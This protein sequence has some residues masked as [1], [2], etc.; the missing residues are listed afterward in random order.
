M[1]NIRGQL[2]YMVQ[3]S[4]F[5]AAAYSP[6][7]CPYGA[8]R[9]LNSSSNGPVASPNRK[10]PIVTRACQSV[11][12]R[13][14]KLSILLHKGLRQL[15]DSC[16]CCSRVGQMYM[17][18]RQRSIPHYKGCFLIGEHLSLIQFNQHT[19]VSSN[20]LAI[21]CKSHQFSVMS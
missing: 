17:H 5:H 1:I 16:G 4:N 6:H 19:A 10:S 12:D 21:V 8:V 11:T 2:R 14:V 13:S 18:I 20:W 7:H 9:L 3:E 15:L